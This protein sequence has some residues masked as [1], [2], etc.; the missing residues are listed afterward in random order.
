[1]NF[2]FCALS[3]LTLLAQHR[4]LDSAGLKSSKLYKPLTLSY[5]ALCPTILSV[6]VSNAFCER[7]FSIMNDLLSDNRNCLST[8]LVKAELLTKINFNMTCAE[9]YDFVR[10]DLELLKTA[11]TQQKYKFKRSSALPSQTQ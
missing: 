5:L 8:D 1:M 3:D 7:V 10:S 6:P 4:M 11:S 2:A 9:F